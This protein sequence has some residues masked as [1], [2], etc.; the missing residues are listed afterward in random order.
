MER[1]DVNITRTQP[2]KLNRC[3]WSTVVQRIYTERLNCTFLVVQL[4]M[5]FEASFTAQI[6][7]V[8]S[9]ETSRPPKNLDF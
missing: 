8:C 5:R 2:I 3:T 7:F 1:K 6:D 4:M 9:A